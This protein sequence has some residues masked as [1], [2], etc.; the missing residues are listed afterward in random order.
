MTKDGI[1]MDALK[2]QA[3]TCKAN[4]ETNRCGC[5]KKNHAQL[6]VAELIECGV[7]SKWSEFNPRWGSLHWDCMG[8][9]LLS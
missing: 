4:S 6:S 8:S 3:C 7:V 1:P 2:I 9:N 5:K